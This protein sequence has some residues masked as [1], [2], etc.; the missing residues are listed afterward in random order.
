MTRKLV[1]V[2]RKIKVHVESRVA[3]DGTVVNWDIVEHPGAVAILPLLGT[4]QVCLLRNQRPNVGATLWEIPAG[5]LEPGEAPELAAVREL[6]EETGYT[7][8]QWRKLGT[9]FPSPGVLTERMHLYVASKLTAGAMH[10]EKD[11]VIEPKILTWN[12]ALQMALSGAIEDAKTML[13]LLLW[14][15]LR[16]AKKPPIL[17]SMGS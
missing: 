4:D 3:S 17:G 5:T 15:R 6:A 10:L 1:H 8:R 11:E 13:A 7:A 12:E 9:Y 2:G 14:Q 16:R